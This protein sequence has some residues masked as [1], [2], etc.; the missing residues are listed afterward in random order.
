MRERSPSFGLC[1]LS[2]TNTHPNKHTHS[3]SFSVSL[4]LPSLS[5]L[6][7][8]LQFHTNLTTQFA[9]PSLKKLEFKI[10]IF[11]NVTIEQREI[12]AINYAVNTK[13]FVTLE[14]FGR[15]TGEVYENKNSPPQVLLFF[16]KH[17]RSITSTA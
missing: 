6:Y 3:L 9:D 8:M 13:F 7:N 15:V 11:R 14:S 2:L 5:I 4:S 17:I 10:L 1:S 12:F 16:A